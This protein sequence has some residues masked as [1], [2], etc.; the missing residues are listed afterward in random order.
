MPDKSYYKAEIKLPGTK[1]QKSRVTV[2]GFGIHVK[3]DPFIRE[4]LVS[5]GD[6]LEGI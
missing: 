4:H 5:R 1:A 2:H 3:S 6:S